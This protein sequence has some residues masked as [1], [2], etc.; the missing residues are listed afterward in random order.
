M[1]LIA[2][3]PEALNLSPETVAEAVKETR[4]EVHEREERVYR[5]NL[6]PH[7]IIITEREI[8]T[9]IVIALLVGA[10]RASA[11]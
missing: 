9:Q 1:G 5:A 11:H 10:P 3:L 8:P 2:R 6:K 7:A 4:R